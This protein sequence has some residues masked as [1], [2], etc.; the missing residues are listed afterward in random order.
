MVF[1]NTSEG[2]ALIQFWPEEHLRRDLTMPKV[3]HTLMAQS[4]KYVEVDAK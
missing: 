4:D 1:L 3:E 2:Y